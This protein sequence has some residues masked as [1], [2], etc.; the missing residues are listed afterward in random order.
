MSSTDPRYQAYADLALDVG[1]NLQAGQRLWLNM[2]IVAA[3]L[4]RVI[5]AA[6]Y[7]RGARYVEMN[8]TDDELTLARFEHAPRDSF[9]EFPVWRTEAML[10]GAQAGDAF[11]SVRS[12]DP[13]LLKDQDPTLVT[14][15]QRTAATH[16]RQY[17]SYITGHKV[18]WCVLNVPI[19]SWATKVFPEAGEEQAMARLW[20]AIAA[21]CRLD[22]PDTVGAWK[23][24][25]D[26]LARRA[27]QMT[28]SAYDALHF[29]GPGT[30]LRVGLVQGHH[31]I[32][33][34][35]TTESG[36]TFTPNVPTE[37]VFTTPHRD[38]T[39]GTLTA[40]KPLNYGGTLIEGLRLRFEEGRV[41]DVQADAGRDVFQGLVDTDEGASRL[42]EVALVPAS[43][44]IAT[45]GILFLSTLYDENAASHVAVGKA[46]S[47]CIAGGGEMSDEELAAA[48][49]NDSLT[50]VDFM[51][52]GPQMDV[53]GVTAD[54]AE[55]P[56]MEQGEWVR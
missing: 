43:S 12:T 52:G 17:L 26:E 10:A 35:S 39:S 11:L 50:H 27:A 53:F 40:S 44:P 23:S 20:D 14:L 21:A 16:S 4:A 15:T 32:G 3:P 54:G 41:V 55:E 34:S 22:Q 51:I 45:S 30:D 24:H 33:G 37:E 8:W 29:V 6:A 46:Y 42:G 48:G 36:I 1:L 47:E 5:A 19:P 9:E 2:P 18:N 25:L 7:R 38:R 13:E 49:V 28:E 56:V 31:W